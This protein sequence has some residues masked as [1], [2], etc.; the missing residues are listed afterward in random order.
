MK[1]LKFLIP[2]V[3]LTGAIITS[4]CQAYYPDPQELNSNRE[5]NEIN[6]TEGFNFGEGTGASVPA[7]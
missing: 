2:L 1:T 4:G 6:K 5:L 7:Y 3:L